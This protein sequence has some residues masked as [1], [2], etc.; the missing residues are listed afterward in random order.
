[1]SRTQPLS[2]FFAALVAF[3]ACVFADVRAGRADDDVDRT[4]RA[5][6]KVA[7]VAGV[8]IT[9]DDAVTIERLV[10]CIVRPE[11]PEIFTCAREVVIKLL[12]AGAVQDIAWCLINL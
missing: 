8:P 5:A 7:N 6:V 11:R 12:P 1:M 10:R 9:E 3:I 2:I 4:V